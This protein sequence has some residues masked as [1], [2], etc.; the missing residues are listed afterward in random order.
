MLAKT[1]REKIGPV[2]WL[3]DKMQGEVIAVC[4]GAILKG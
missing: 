3:L 4:F 1:K 2:C